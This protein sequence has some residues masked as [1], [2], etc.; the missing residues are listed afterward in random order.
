MKEQLKKAD[1]F[2]LAIIAATLIV[3]SSR[4]VWS[5]PMTVAAVV[6]GLLVL[7][8]IV[9]K[10]PEI[11]AGLGRRS[12]KYGINSATSVILVL[13]ILAFV[14]YLGAQ[15]SRRVDMTKEKIFSLSDQSVQ[16]ASQVKEDV[17]VKAFYSGGEYPPARDLLRLYSHQNSKISFEF[18]DPDK[19]PQIAQ[20]NQVTVYGTLENPLSG[21][22]S[23]SETL[24]LDLG[25]K[26]QRIE[27]QNAELKEEDL[28]NAL[29][30]LVKGVQKTI[31]FT[32][33]HGEKQMAS[34]DQ[35]SGYQLAK[36]GLEKE[37]YVVKALNLI[38][39]G[40]VPADGTVVVM[41]G[42]T[43]EPVSAELDA[44]DTFLNGGGSVLLLLDPPPGASLKDFLKKWSIDAGNNFVVDVSGMGKIVGTGPTMPLVA[45]YEGHRITQGFNVMTFFPLVR[46]ILPAKPPVEGI[47][48]EPLLRTNEASWGESDLSPGDKKQVEFDEKTDIKGPVQ[49]AAVATKTMGDKK[50]RL[51]VVGDSDFAANGFYADLGNGNLFT[52]MVTFLAQDENFI[53]IKAKDPGNRPVTMTEAQAKSVAWLVQ[54]LLP[55]GVLIAGIS[56]WVKRRK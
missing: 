45:K 28:T 7:I 37:N 43:A 5:I 29:L 34:T 35:H 30:K 11:R 13:G 36:M 39:E 31:Y 1:L 6:G 42:P 33:G 14:N 38:Q 17:H 52:N 19:Q 20:Q 27:K 25:G 22:T 44:L 40:K 2:G 10:L 54:V 50:G 8:S 46:S 51:I 53:S 48:V 55:G 24:I 12:S 21:E 16:V 3:Y 9:L 47:V 23:R 4:S 15:H 32:E 41:A 18:I 56:V 49:I 26:T